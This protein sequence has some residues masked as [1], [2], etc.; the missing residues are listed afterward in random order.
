MTNRGDQ[1]SFVVM[2]EE[3]QPG[4]G[5]G[6]LSKGAVYK[7]IYSQDGLDDLHEGMQS[8]WDSFV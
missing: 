5:E 3:G 8:T 6:E 7:S 2:V 4:R 1:K